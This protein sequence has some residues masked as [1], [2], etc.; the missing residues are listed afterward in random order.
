MAVSMYRVTLKSDGGRNVVWVGPASSAAAAK[1]A[2]CKAENAP[3]RSI[4]KVER[5]NTNGNFR[6]MD[7][8]GEPNKY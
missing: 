8:N 6:N 5:R 2:A 4:M 7:R 3:E 1:K